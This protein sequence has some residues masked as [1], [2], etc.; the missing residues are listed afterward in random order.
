[1]TVDIYGLFE[2]DWMVYFIFTAVFLVLVNFV[3]RKWLFD[4]K[5]VRDMELKNAMGLLSFLLILIQLTLAVIGG[6]FPQ[7]LLGL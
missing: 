4:P 2:M 6:F 7:V 5:N 1:M 3:F